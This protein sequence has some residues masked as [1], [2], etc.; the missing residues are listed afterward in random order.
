MAPIM[1]TTGY[2]R[3]APTR[4]GAGPCPRERG[5]RVLVSIRAPGRPVAPRPPELLTSW[6]SPRLTVLVRDDHAWWPRPSC[7]AAL[8]ARRPDSERRR[9]PRSCADRRGQDPDPRDRHRGTLWLPG[10]HR[11]GL[12]PDERVRRA[13]VSALIR[14]IGGDPATRTVPRRRCSC[15]SAFGTGAVAVRR[16]ERPAVR[17][18]LRPVGVRCRDARGGAAGGAEFGFRDAGELGQLGRGH[19]RRRRVEAGCKGRL[20]LGELGEQG[21]AVVHVRA[22]AVAVSRPRTG[23]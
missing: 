11:R 8:D 22:T 19:D 17:V 5:T 18:V 20:D 13:T 1:P 21:G 4:P 2:H 10:G 12:V 23:P 7:S 15:P 9:C 16:R 6:P 14:V 3:A